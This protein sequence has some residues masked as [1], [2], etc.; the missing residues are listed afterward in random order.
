MLQSP[1]PVIIPV[2]LLF[3]I[4]IYFKIF[5]HYLRVHIHDLS[6]KLGLFGIMGIQLRGT[7]VGF[8]INT[9]I[10]ADTNNIDVKPMELESIYLVRRSPDDVNTCI[11]VLIEINSSNQRNE[12][13]RIQ[14]MHF[15]GISKEDIIAFF[16]KDNEED[17]PKT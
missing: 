8:I 1:Y 15:Y 9:L 7:P 13:A 4:V 17:S 14:E 3:V 12:L 10:R 6:H 16:Q 2:V 11:D 5:H